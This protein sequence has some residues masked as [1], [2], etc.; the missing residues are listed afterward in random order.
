MTF[1]MFFRNA[2]FKEMVGKY[3]ELRFVVFQEV[4]LVGHIK[5]ISKWNV[6]LSNT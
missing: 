2:A 1:K 6:L 4:F 5:N 3:I